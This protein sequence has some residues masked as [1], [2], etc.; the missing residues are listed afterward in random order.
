MWWFGENLASG[1]GIDEAG[2]DKYESSVGVTRVETMLGMSVFTDFDSEK[3]FSWIV[4]VVGVCICK[5]NTKW[6]VG[7]GVWFGSGKKKAVQ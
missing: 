6:V 1:E 4:E 5:N 2:G 7:R 3:V